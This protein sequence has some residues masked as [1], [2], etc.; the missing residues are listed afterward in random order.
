MTLKR[1]RNVETMSMEKRRSLPWK[2]L[3]FYSW[4]IYFGILINLWFYECAARIYTH[5]PVMLKMEYGKWEMYVRSAWMD[6]WMER[7]KRQR[8]RTRGRKQ[9]ESSAYISKAGNKYFTLTKKT[10]WNACLCIWIVVW[11]VANRC[12]PL[13]LLT[14]RQS[15]KHIK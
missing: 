4:T 1:V 11:R 10:A 13:T 7:S 15:P 12:V 8:Q 5:M 14:Y 2:I 9:T 3:I 6:G